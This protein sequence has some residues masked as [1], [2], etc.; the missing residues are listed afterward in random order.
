M[1]KL[2]YNEYKEAYKEA[3]HQYHCNAEQVSGVWGINGKDFCEKYRLDYDSALEYEDEEFMND[4][5]NYYIEERTKISRII[6]DLTDDQD[7]RLQEYCQ[8]E[9]CFDGEGEH[10]W[11]YVSTTLL[12]QAYPEYDKRY[13]EDKD[14]K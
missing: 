10:F 14:F 9:L 3:R 13:Y 6:G 5:D 4:C 8:N 12:A 2:T 11:W 1:S 7:V